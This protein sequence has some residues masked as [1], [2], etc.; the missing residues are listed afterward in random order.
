MVYMLLTVLVHKAHTVLYR[1]AAQCVECICCS[2]F[3]TQ[4]S[5]VPYF[6]PPDTHHHHHHQRH[7]TSTTT[8]SSGGSADSERGDDDG[9]H[10]V[11]CVHGLD[12]NSADLRLVRTYL[13]LALPGARLDFLM[14][15]INQK[16]T[17]ADLDVMTDNLVKEILER[18]DNY[19][20]Q[21]SRVR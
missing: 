19:G 16:D 2:D 11:V 3:P 13:E 12:G 9:L 17:F 20:Y 6:W 1:H 21:P 8:S 15:D 14:S 5:S 18:V 10:L 4:F 7:D